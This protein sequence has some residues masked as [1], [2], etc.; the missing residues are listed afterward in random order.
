MQPRFY[1]KICRRGSQIALSAFVA[2]SLAA[3]P[4]SAAEDDVVATVDGNVITESD[5]SFAVGEYQAQLKQIPAAKRREL[6]LD[7]LIDVAL[8]ANA[9]EREGME[10]DP[11]YKERFRFLRRRTLRD[12][13]FLRQIRDAVTDEVVRVQYDSD[14]KNYV[15]KSELRARHIL[16]KTLEEAQAV[17]KELDGGADFA[18]V[19]KK[20]STGPSGP[21]GGDLGFFGP[22]RMVPVFEKAALAL[23]LGSYTKE[24]VKTKFGFHIIK[25]EETRMSKPVE[26]DKVKDKLRD[27]MVRERFTKLLKSL[28]EKAKIDIVKA[29]DKKPE[30]EAAPKATPDA[31]KKAE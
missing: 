10:E 2:A 19:A 31:E 24:P 7:V 27:T 15:P 5:L 11:E 3:L 28:R 23:A 4:V 16:V 9:A 8:M 17:I 18:E 22:G 29:E 20:S 21:R 30:P 12:V 6:V 13:Y 14:I 26:F 1:Q 25:A